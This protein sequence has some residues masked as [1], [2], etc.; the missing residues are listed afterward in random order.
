[1]DLKNNLTMFISSCDKFSD[2]W[3][4][5]V[6]FLKKNWQ[7]PEMPVILSTDVPTDRSFDGLRIVAGGKEKEWSQRLQYA[8]QFVET[9]YV[10][11]TLDDYFIITPID[12]EKIAN[13]LDLMEKEHLDYVR[14]EGFVR[15][16]TRDK[17]PGYRKT[18][19]LDTGKTYSVN[20][21]SGIWRKSFLEKTCREPKTAWQYEVS[22]AGIA[23]EENAR[24][25]ICKDHDYHYLDVVRKG[26]LLNKAA[27]YFRKHD[28]YHG[29]REI[30][31]R[32]E[33]LRIFVCTWGVRLMPP[34]LT[35][36][37]RK[38]LMK[39]GHHFFSQEA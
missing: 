1:M 21:T 17:V 34:A 30:I 15:H 3:E 36:M 9:E 7:E 18:Y 32:K 12:L 33:E 11:V 20:L 8:L 35:N 25:M 14:L 28:L 23:R 38:F 26:K 19:R 37:V 16:P 27:R 29:D 4:L 24:C 22:L 10:F 2:L 13:I 6:D 39:R 31:A 5:H